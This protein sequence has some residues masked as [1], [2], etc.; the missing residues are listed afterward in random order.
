MDSTIIHPETG[1]L[2]K[3]GKLDIDN[4]PSPDN[5]NNS[6]NSNNNAATVQH[7]ESSVVKQQGTNDKIAEVEDDPH[8]AAFQEGHDGPKSLSTST[9]IAIFVSPKFHFY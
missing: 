1:D 6:N 9:F 2:E 4:A 8:I 5:S 7:V 3:S